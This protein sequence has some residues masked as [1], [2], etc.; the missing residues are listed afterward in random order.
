MCRSSCYMSGVCVVLVY[1]YIRNCIRNTLPFTTFWFDCTC[2]GE[3][4]CKNNTNLF[5]MQMCMNYEDLYV[6]SFK[7]RCS[8]FDS[9]KDLF[10]SLIFLLLYFASYDLWGCCRIFPKFILLKEKRFI[11]LLLPTTT[12]RIGYT[13]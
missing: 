2:Y 4:P 7:L 1:G 3:I 13:V 10:S 6:F 8:G 11:Y 12:I 9:E 5:V